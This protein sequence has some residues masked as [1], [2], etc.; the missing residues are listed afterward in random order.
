MFENFNFDKK[1]CERVSTVGL[2]RIIVLFDWIQAF[3]DKFGLLDTDW[4]DGTESSNTCSDPGKQVILKGLEWIV[5]SWLK[6]NQKQ[7]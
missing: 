1:V 7:Y 4:G 3:W 2:E 6:F 5:S